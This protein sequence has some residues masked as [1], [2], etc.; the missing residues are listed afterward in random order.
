M[1]VSLEKQLILARGVIT[2]HE[3]NLG[4]CLSCTEKPFKFYP[5]ESGEGG[6]HKGGDVG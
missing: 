4:F 3:Q 2:K 6:G 1:Y 5:S